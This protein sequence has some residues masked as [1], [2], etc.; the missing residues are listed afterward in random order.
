[1]LRTREELEELLH[2][3]EENLKKSR[4]A[5]R[6]LKAVMTKVNKVI[7]PRKSVKRQVPK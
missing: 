3:S 1:M 2:K 6:K 7:G 4:S 5:H